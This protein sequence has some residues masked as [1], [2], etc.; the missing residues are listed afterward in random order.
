M[1]TLISRLRAQQA[2]VR[3]FGLSFAMLYLEL[4]L[5][6]FTSAQVL[7]L[8]YFSNFVL[9]SVFLGIG[10]GFL[11]VQKATRLLDLTPQVLLLL[12]AYVLVSQVDVSY[13]R[14]HL[15]Q[16][17]FG[18]NSTLL[19]IPL[20]LSLA[21]L[22]G[23]TALI[24]ASLAQEA[25]RC[26]SAYRP[27]VAYSIDI[28]GSLSG[29]VAFTLCAYLGLAPPFWFASAG[30][31]IVLLSRR[32]AWPNALVL[33]AGVVLLIIAAAP[34]HYVKW[35][36][37]QRIDVWPLEPPNEKLG[38]A[39][40]ANGVG[41]QSMQPVGT[42][43]PIYDYPYTEVLRRRGNKPYA[44]V[45]IIGAGSGSDVSYALHYGAQRIDAVEIDREIQAAGRQFH[46]AKPYSDPRVNVHITDGR[47]FMQR[48]TRRYDLVIF[49][50]PDSLAALSGFANIRLE[51]F[52]FT[53]QSFEQ[54]RLL[55]KDDGVL[56][57]YNYYRKAWLADKLAGMLQGVFGH[58]PLV[59]AYTDERGGMLA[60]L[61]IGPK[62]RDSVELQN[63]P[64]PATD[65]WPFLYMERPTLPSMYVWIMLLFVGC[66]VG[67]LVLAGQARLRSLQ[68]HGA[69][70]LMGAAFLL[71]E[72]KSVIQFLLL[73]GATWLV[74]ALVFA[75]ILIS[76]LLAN[77]LV[78]RLRLKRPEPLFALLLGSLI[79]QYLV[80]PDRLLGVDS[81][82]LRYLLASALLLSP[83]FF[84]NLVFGFLFAGTPM[85][86]TAFGWNIVGTMLGGALEY[87]SIAIGY[88]T[89]TLLVIALYTGCFVWS[90]WTLR[91]R[92]APATPSPS[93]S[94]ES[95]PGR[96][97]KRR[98]A[99]ART[100]R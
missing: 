13:L 48:A 80:P 47:A 59:Q 22:F 63:S 40:T 57:L 19:R 72:T 83:I 34:T 71:L 26:F 56:V 11:L 91:G 28:A 39:L 55:L 15:G 92:A 87:T 44:D 27:I 90:Y 51:S 97:S 29:I 32:E 89:L 35:S 86:A 79:V 84:A 7:Y 21:L 20:W 75:A 93:P 100:M 41:H 82:A 50:L 61:A 18:I 95:V 60:A 24:F 53:Q 17:F 62:L 68:A 88:R 76:V 1:P 3:L 64:P 37:Y 23:L 74:N 16:L 73:F 67:G 8:G 54:A 6:R 85:A 58:A 49:A 81:L 31:L 46:P 2:G 70:A 98:E 99:A 9:I 45:L 96:R 69:F 43:E 36:P 38:F 65:D 77:L 14:E 94:P 10:L 25:G 33:L 12:I 30:L 4:A 66:G 42:K 52:L 5:I 78:D